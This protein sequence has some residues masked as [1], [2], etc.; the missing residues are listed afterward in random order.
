M[1]ELIDGYTPL[2]RVKMTP[3]R[4]GLTKEQADRQDMAKEYAVCI[5]EKANA[6][7]I[8]YAK[9]GGEWVA[10]PWSDRFLIR[11][12]IEGLFVKKEVVVDEKIDHFKKALITDRVPLV[13]L[14]KLVKERHK[15][16]LENN[17]D[18]VEL[19]NQMIRQLLAV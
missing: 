12:L 18:A 1:T 4:W 7:I 2:Y 11:D 5:A 9:I 10:N 17:P 3:E 15:Y 13:Q 6:G 8:V 19:I 14:D 16:A